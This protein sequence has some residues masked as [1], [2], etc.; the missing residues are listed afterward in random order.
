MNEKIDPVGYFKATHICK[1]RGG[2]YV[3][4]TKDVV[5]RK[6]VNV[7]NIERRNLVVN[8][9][10][11]VLARTLGG[12]YQNASDDVPFINRLVLGD[13]EKSSNLPNLSDTGLVSEIS[14]LSA[15]PG[16]TFLLADHLDASPDISFP[17]AVT[18][19]P[20]SGTW[21]AGNGV[22]TIDANGDTI[23][24]DAT[25]DFISVI[26]IQL[27]DQITINN[28]ST[29]P[30]VF[31]VREVRSTTE[32]VLHNPYGYTGTGVEWRAET[33]G[34]QMLVSRLVEGNDFDQATWGDGVVVHEAGLLFN[35]DTLFNR[36]VFAPH[37]EE[38]G[39][40]LQSDEATGVE[41]SVRFEWLVT[42]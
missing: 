31:G 37:D 12:Y 36:V 29:N 20:L 25:V 2:L 23:L 40:L 22:I 15:T 33:P 3:P 32:L 42:I 14:D 27:T 1:T 13:G 9:G 17:S 30:L 38:V 6:D 41:I 11:Q 34:T 35:N 10:R 16:G 18:R 8:S 28:S 4:L 5:A 24:T 21:T 7:Q 39:V 26:N 19:W